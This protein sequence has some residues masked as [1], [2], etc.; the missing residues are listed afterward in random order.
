MF[1]PMGI[2]HITALNGLDHILF[3]MALCVRYTI[4]DW[5]KLLVLITA[6]TIGHSLTL[7]LSSLRIIDVPQVITEF[8]IALTILITA[9]NNCFVKDF[10]FRNKYPTIYFLALFFGCIHGLGFSSV[11]RNMFGSNESIAGQLL[12]FNLGLEVGQLII[13]SAILI[14]SF[15]LLDIFRVNRRS[16][17]LFVSGGIA[18][19]AIE[20]AV[21]RYP[22]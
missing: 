21:Q 18:A 20:M 7:A 12:G 22:F 6:F 9:I 2:E 10:V 1:F 5:K 8:L 14:L 11:L 17:L 3:I 15:V 16:Y 13:V 4:G 19:L